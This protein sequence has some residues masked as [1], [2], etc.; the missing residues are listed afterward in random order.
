MSLPSFTFTLHAHLI[1]SDTSDVEGLTRALLHEVRE[2]RAASAF[3]APTQ[4][5]AES[6]G[7]S[8][9]LVGNLRLSVEALALPKLIEFISEWALKHPH[10]TMQLGLQAKQA[11]S[12]N[13]RQV[14]ESARF[15]NFKLHGQTGQAINVDALMHTLETDDNLTTTKLV[16]FALDLIQADEGRARLEHYLFNGTPIQRNYAALY[17]KRR[18]HEALLAEAVQRGRIDV[19]QAFSK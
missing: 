14:A 6:G 17:F 3:R 10:L 2:L 7:Q 11:M 13:S 16:D 8:T 5:L 18:G 19:E 15:Q 9:I 1:G 4:R 12:P